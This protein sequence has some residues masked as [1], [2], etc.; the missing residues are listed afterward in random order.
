M[1]ENLIN[2]LDVLFS[3]SV[4][5]ESFPIFSFKEH[6][7]LSEYVTHAMQY[8]ENENVKSQ[9]SKECSIWIKP[10]NGSFH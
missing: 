6:L 3:I 7:F 9:T 5:V 8:W 4:V 2:A 1:D 10:Q